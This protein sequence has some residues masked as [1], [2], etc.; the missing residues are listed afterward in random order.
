MV[1]ITNLIIPGWSGNIDVNKLSIFRVDFNRDD[2]P[3]STLQYYI[4]NGEYQS[5][6]PFGLFKSNSQY[7]IISKE[8]TILKEIIVIKNYIGEVIEEIKFKNFN[9]SKAISIFIYTLIDHLYIEYG[10]EKPIDIRTFLGKSA[11]GKLSYRKELINTISIKD[12]KKFNEINIYKSVNH[13]VFINNNKFIVSFLPNYEIYG[14]LLDLPLSLEDRRLIEN[15]PMWNSL[16]YL[17]SEKFLK[18]FDEYCSYIYNRLEEFNFI[19]EP[20]I[21]STYKNTSLNYP[22]EIYINFINQNLDLIKNKSFKMNLLDFFRN[23]LNLIPIIEIEIIIDTYKLSEV[24]KQILEDYLKK[25]EDSGIFNIKSKYYLNNIDEFNFS[26]DYPYLVLINDKYK[27]SEY[28]YATIKRKADISKAINIS[29]LE[30]IDDFD[31]NLLLIWLAFNF[32][33]NKTLIWYFNERP[34]FKRIISF[35]VIFEPDFDI[36]KVSGI[37]FNTIKHNLKR[38]KEIYF[39]KSENQERDDILNDILNILEIKYRFDYN[40]EL[41]IFEQGSYSEDFI[42]KIKGKSYCVLIRR[43]NARIFYNSQYN[44]LEIP[45]NGSYIQLF[46]NDLNRFLLINTG[47]PDIPEQ[48][49]P[50]PLLV[51][52]SSELNKIN[53]KYILQIIFYLT[54][55]Q[56]ESFSKVNLPFLLQYKKKGLFNKIPYKYDEENPF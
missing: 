1:Q 7:Y 51:T 38:F 3:I 12:A 48:G 9:D 14:N 15:D 5:N 18:R 44:K 16:V 30:I 20:E 28:V 10:F 32:R 53:S 42:E 25:L 37:I 31:E 13:E 24:S 54:F 43:P 45:K 49:L 46:D 27:G 56:T 55:Y 19:Y 29:T 11:K 6:F 40:N 33:I 2:I 21:N 35:S 50:N 8:D 4:K 26:N 34:I 23:N 52:M 41:Y 17:D 22:N 39:K 47:Y 36:F